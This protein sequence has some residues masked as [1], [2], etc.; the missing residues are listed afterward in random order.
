VRLPQKLIDLVR[1]HIETYDQLRTLVLIG[2]HPDREWTATS[3][4][5]ALS[6]HSGQGQE[7]LDHLIKSGF[8]VRLQNR[9]SDTFRC[10]PDL[11]LPLRRLTTPT[12][13]GLDAGGHGH[14]Q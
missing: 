14:G 10:R 4:E 1:E 13:D 12:F 3:V 5:A 9:G 8:L 2:R 6:L 7:L 11:A